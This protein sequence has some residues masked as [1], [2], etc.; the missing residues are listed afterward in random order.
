MASG[1]SAL[2]IGDDP[3]VSDAVPTVPTVVVGAWKGGTWKTSVSVA[4]AE[5]LAWAGLEV[6]LL[7]SD[8]QLD[9]RRR[10]GLLDDGSGSRNGFGKGGV[11]VVEATR[12]RS[13]S[14][15]YRGEIA[16]I[17]TFDAVV[18]DTP[19]VERAG[20]MPGVLLVVP[21]DGSTDAWANCARMFQMTPQNTV[22]VLLQAGCADQAEWCSEAQALLNVV[23]RKDWHFIT[24]PIPA[25]AAIKRAHKD[26]MSVWCLS[27]RGHTAKFCRAVDVLAELLWKRIRPEAALPRMPLAER[28]VTVSGWDDDDDE[29]E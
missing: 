3:S 13:I 28:I 19:P 22:A 4:L 20:R 1:A 29:D 27:R 7:H 24:E 23:G 10:M 25:S 21:L 9:A 2:S 15:L 16:E 17:G 26:A 6:M 12:E 18:V 11:T 8:R 14:V 5:R